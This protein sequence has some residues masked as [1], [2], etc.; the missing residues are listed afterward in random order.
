MEQLQSNVISIILIF[1][2]YG[3]CRMFACTF[4]MVEAWEALYWISFN[5]LYVILLAKAISPF[6]LLDY[7]PSGIIDKRSCVILEQMH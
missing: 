7:R 5:N 1:R 2:R 4:P 3:L 6:V